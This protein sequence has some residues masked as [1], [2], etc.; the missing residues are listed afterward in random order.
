MKRTVLLISI[1][2]MIGTTALA[3]DP[4]PASRGH[5]IGILTT[6]AADDDVVTLRVAAL[7]RGYLARELRREGFDVFD[8][9][10]TLE[11][12]ERGAEPDADYFV[13][14]L[15]GDTADHGYG[16]VGVAGR[17]AGV[18]MELIVSKVAASL[19][20]YDG[21]TLEVIDDF[22]VYAQG[23]AFMPTAI[24]IGGRHTAFWVGVPFHV[25]K[26]RAV[27]KAAARDAA[28]SIAGALESES[29]RD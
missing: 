24:G 10:A 21:R 12:I 2:L 23:K 8:A 27:A 20:L 22:D 11:E 29:G 17:H 28:E 25:L 4:T 26:H 3:F 13:E 9:R 15:R 1:L 14:F 7:M 5:R 6:T 19:R 16:G 18:D